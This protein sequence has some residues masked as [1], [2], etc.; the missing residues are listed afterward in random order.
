MEPNNNIIWGFADV[1]DCIM[2][3]SRLCPEPGSEVVAVDD[4]G[5]VCGWLTPKQK[6][7]LALLNGRMEMVLTTARTSKGVSQLSLPVKGYV[8]ASFGGVIRTPGGQSEPRFRALMT[9][10]AAAASDTLKGLLSL[11]Q[12]HCTSN[13]IDARLRI[14]ADDGLDLFLSIKHNKRD[15]VA[16][17]AL[18]E[19]LAAALAPGW[20]LHFNGNF[21]AAMPPFLGKD[22]AVRWFI[23]NIARPGD[24]TVGL[25]D[26]RS[27]LPFMGLCDL[28]ITPTGSQIFS[29]CL[30]NIQGGNL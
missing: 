8:I 10:Q 1:D 14:A 4:K 23:D 5:A 27:D 2:T 19:K 9:E 6:Q 25:G 26:S 7:F 17:A 20:H 29:H 22:K 13:D 16:M 12:A 28:A 11:M 15:L 3:S 30:S 21:L 18:K 24:L